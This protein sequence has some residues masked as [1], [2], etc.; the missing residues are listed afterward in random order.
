[1]LEIKS[2]CLNNIDN[3]FNNLEK[4]DLINSESKFFYRS[5][6]IISN[7]CYYYLYPL[8]EFLNTSIDV[9]HDF[10]L[11]NSYLHAY[12]H[13]LDQSFDSLED[14]FST[15]VRSF[16]I[17]AY[18][19]TNYLEWLI[20]RY[21]PKFKVRFYEYYNEYSFYLI[22][23]K[24]WNFPHCYLSKYRSA[25]NI[26][27]KAFMLLFPLELCKKNTF[28]YKKDVLIKKLFINY[29]S[30]ALLADDLIDLDFDIKHCY[31]TYPIAR[32]FD[33]KKELP[34]NKIELTFLLP[35]MMKIL[36]RFLKNINL[37]EKQINK[38]SV[39]IDERISQIK[40]ELIKKE[41]KL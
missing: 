20:N 31:L 15:K 17:S 13:F 40:N 10:F 11:Y 9:N 30:F 2:E 14:N 5:K 22:T 4:E 21:N 12:I 38:H 34:N 25:K 6:K 32:Y 24:K 36:S 19:L 23:E 41:I 18:C 33:L 39:I 16:Q 8:E 37:L 3:I 28:I 27:K 7:A 29:Y 26:H 1:M 35:Q